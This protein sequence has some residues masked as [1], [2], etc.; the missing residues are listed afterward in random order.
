MK[1]NRIIYWTATGLLSA[2]MLFSAAMYVFNHAAVEQSMLKL[3]YPVFI[4]YPHAIAKILGLIAILTNRSALLKEWAYAGFFF[5]FLLA[6]AS[7][8]V[9]GV[10]G[11][12]VALF[13]I[14][15]LIVSR[16][17]SDRVRNTAMI[18]V[19]NSSVAIN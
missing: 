13:A 2:L 12:E 4:I 18:Q 6:A 10:P 16:F 15:L 5:D 7:S 11:G 8:F 14:L 1:T 3:G 17:Y 19:L 9:A